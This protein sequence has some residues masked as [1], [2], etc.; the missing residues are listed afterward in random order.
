LSLTPDSQPNEN[1]I[2]AIIKMTLALFCIGEKNGGSEAAMAEAS[3]DTLTPVQRPHAYM[4]VIYSHGQS[5]PLHTD[6]I[7]AQG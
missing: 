1:N 2:T 3:E 7:D 6:D 4:I 5:I